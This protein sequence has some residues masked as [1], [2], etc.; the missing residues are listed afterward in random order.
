[1]VGL[2]DGFAVGSDEGGKLGTTVVG[3]ND[4]MTDGIL[5]D[6]FIVGSDEGV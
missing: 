2:D 1:M 5:L 3:F 4:G 6:G